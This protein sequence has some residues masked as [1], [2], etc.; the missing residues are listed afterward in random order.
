MLRLPNFASRAVRGHLS[1]K[2]TAVRSF[3][4]GPQTVLLN[5][6][7]RPP[8]GKRNGRYISQPDKGDVSDIAKNY[9]TTMHDGR[10]LSPPATLDSMGFA[11]E[12][13]PTKVK[14]FRDDAEV[15]KVYYEEMRALVKKTSG[16]KHVL[17]FD[18]TIR[19]SG[20]TNLNAAAGGSAAPVPRVHCDYTA[21]GAPRRLKKLGKEGI[22]SLV[23][24]RNL[25]EAEVDELASRRFAFINV[26]RSISDEAPV[27]RKPLAVCDEK[28]IKPEDRFLYEL[29]FP[30]R[31]G[32]NYS[33][34]FSKDHMWYYYPQQTKDEALVFKVYDKAEDGPRFVFHTAFDDPRCPAD[35][36]ARISIECRTIAFFDDNSP[37]D[38]AF[39][40]TIY[41]AHE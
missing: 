26:W 32:E 33:L 20:N 31:V 25:T 9:E 23:R 41:P 6:Q 7:E 38:L 8:A 30:D 5:Y 28:S 35:A 39:E 24:G 2:N 27:Y 10:A 16:A 3:A 14:N 17:V 40:G 18:H 22:N 4:A 13:H 36:P 1:L 21:E 37:E 19:E 11:L 34:E 12:H 15:A 29:I